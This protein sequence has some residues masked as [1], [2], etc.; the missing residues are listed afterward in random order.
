MYAHTSVTPSKPS[1]LS[2]LCERLVIS[3]LV[4]TVKHYI[5]T[6][7]CAILSVRTSGKW[8]CPEYV[9]GVLLR[10]CIFAISCITGWHVSTVKEHMYLNQTM[11]R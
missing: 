6:E 2:I 9:V 4:L 11:T 7:P 10:M 5:V 1:G 3:W 8:V